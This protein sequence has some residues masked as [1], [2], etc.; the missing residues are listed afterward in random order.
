MDSVDVNALQASLGPDVDLSQIDTDF[1]DF[2]DADQI[3]Q[4]ADA[5]DGVD[6]EGLITQLARFNH[7]FTSHPFG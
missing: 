5:L 3:S 4:L 1:V 7:L 6:F 2:N